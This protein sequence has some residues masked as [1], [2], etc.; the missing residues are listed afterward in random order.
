M[1]NKLYRWLV[2]DSA[3]DLLEYMLLGGA[4]AIVGLVGM[5]AFEGVISAVY[6]SWEAGTQA[7]WEPE[8]PQ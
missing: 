6:A 3:Q 1:Q 7:I 8:D 4:V 2:D 5:S